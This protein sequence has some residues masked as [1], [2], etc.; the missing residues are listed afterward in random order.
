MSF[1][2]FKFAK[3]V[4]HKLDAE[5]AHRLTL[6]SLKV[7]LYPRQ[8]EGDDARLGQIIWGLSFPNPLGIAA[9][10]DKDATVVTSLSNMGLGFVEVGTVTPRPQPGNP[11]PRIFRL[12]LDR[13]VINRLGFNSSGHQAVFDHLKVQKI[14]IVLGVNVGANKDSTNRAEDYV[15]GLQKFIEFADY[16]TIN[17]SSPNTPGL[18]DLQKPKELTALLSWL[19]AARGGLMEAGH[20]WC[21]LLVK[22]AP[23][24]DLGE[25]EQTVECL[26]EHDIDGIIISNT[27]TSREGL[28]DPV[29]AGESGGLSGRPLFQKSTEMLARVYL[30]TKGKI[31]LIG[32][33]GI[34]SGE[35]ALAKIEAGASLLQLYTGLIYSGPKLVES[36]KKRLLEEAEREKLRDLR[37]L[38]G[39]K[40]EHWAA[41][42]PTLV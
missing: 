27:T 41:N 13:A 11:K 37:P 18:R 21:P 34:E 25:L 5:Q 20:K 16:F 31:P 8:A 9:G 35:T 26:L 2:L 10:F 17:V 33:G 40:A 42:A 23:D 14:P 12:E 30:M 4:L 28:S 19:I 36:I 29:L 24:M 32:V 15:E 38:I 39:S 3:P 7:G 1:D 6:L 22:L